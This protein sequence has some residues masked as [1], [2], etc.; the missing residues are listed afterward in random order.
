ML[1]KLKKNKQQIEAKEI[2]ESNVEKKHATNYEIESPGKLVLRRLK[3]NKFAMIG[4]ALLIFMFV[5]SFIG[6]LLSPYGYNDRSALVKAA[7]SLKHWFGTDYLGRDVLTRVM[8]G[9]RISIAVGVVSVVISVVVGTLVGS[10]AGYYGGKIDYF[11]MAFTDIFL[12]IPFLPIVI[13]MGSM[14]SDLKVNPNM[15]I[16][17]LMF[18][19]GL[20]SWPSIARLVRGE[21]LSLREQEFM[22]ATESLG[23]KDTR[24]IIKH[25]IPNVIPT[26]IVN[27]TLG[28]A[29][30]ILTE[31]ALSYL[32][33][34]VVEPTPSWGN[35]ISASNKAIDLQK[36][37][38]LWMPPGACMVITVMA[39]NLFGDA[40]RDAL[41]PKKRR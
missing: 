32:G 21:I 17:A 6:P 40:L 18:M 27:A 9:G 5:F 13:L 29:S 14:L 26:I 31:S 11:L 24:K 41:D 30:A 22:Q 16:V 4:L 37:P 28:V 34:G 8:V 19:L 39:V 36:R 12:S 33:M 15:R 10:I 3:Q 7:P 2:D 23:L 35:M 1:D 20:L 25:L 38:W